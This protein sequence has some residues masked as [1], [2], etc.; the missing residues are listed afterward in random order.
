MSISPSSEVFYALGPGDTLTKVAAL[1]AKR[2][3]GREDRSTMKSI[4]S[5]NPHITDPNR[6]R[7]GD[8]LRLGPLD[9]TLPPGPSFATDLRGMGQAWRNADTKTR[10]LLLNNYDIFDW[11]SRR[12]DELEFVNNFG[13]ASANTLAEVR[14]MRLTGSMSGYAYNLMSSYRELLV[15]RR[16]M[17]TTLGRYRIPILGTPTLIL[18]AQPNH[19][20]GI[21]NHLKRLIDLAEKIR[22]GRTLTILEALLEGEK[23]VETG[24]ITRDVAKTGKQAARG[25]IKVLTGIGAASGARIICKT[26]FKHDV[27][28][29]TIVCLGAIATAVG[30][31]G[32]V[33]NAISDALLGPPVEL[34]LPRLK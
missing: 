12:R 22:F 17:V 28:L 20:Y 19:W 33:A 5:M 27:R 4:L 1:N 8:I 9:P 32:K 26:A 31:S 10:E 24:I 2:C 14:Q 7:I 6:I 21:A 25:T 23:V 18:D 29:G 3:L 34:E 15:T 11:L 30:G 16:Q 13:E